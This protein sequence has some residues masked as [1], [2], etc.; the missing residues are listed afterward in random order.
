MIVSAGEALTLDDDV[1]LEVLWPPAG[2]EGPLVLR[3][4]YGRTGVLLMGVRHDDC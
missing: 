4:A 1:A 3:V 2:V